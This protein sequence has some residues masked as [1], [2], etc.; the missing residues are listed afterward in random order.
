M[1]MKTATL[2]AC[3]LS[4]ATFLHAQADPPMPEY[5]L[6]L[7]LPTADNLKAWDIGMIFTHRFVAPVKDHGKDVYGLDGMAYPG[8][9]VTIGIKPIKG[10]N[11]QIYRTSDNKTLTFALQQQLWNHPRFRLAARLERFDETVERRVTSLGTIGITGMAMQVPA[12]LFITKDFV[13]SLVPTYLSRTTT[14][15]KSVFTAGAGVRFSFLETWSLLAEYY[16]RPSK[17]ASS[18]PSAFAAGVSY[19]TYKHTFTLLGTNA[20]GT[21]AHQALSGDY[22]GGP[23]ESNQW[24]LGFNITRLF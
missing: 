7:N 11:G 21:T 23:R 3:A 2:L 17:I 13:V 8:L 14:Q 6:A 18:N 15:D 19:K 4:T 9:G 16:P 1:V 22:G 20:P 24:S 10:L 5:P 12:E